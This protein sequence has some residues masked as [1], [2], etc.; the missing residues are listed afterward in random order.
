[1]LSIVVML[2]FLSAMG[3]DEPG[4]EQVFDRFAPILLG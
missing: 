1:M 4:P 3:A 2:P